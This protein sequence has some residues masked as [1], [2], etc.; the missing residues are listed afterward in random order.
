[1]KNDGNARNEIEND[2]DGNVR[3]EIED[4]NDQDGNVRNENDQTCKNGDNLVICGRT[5]I[6]EVR[7]LVKKRP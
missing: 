2:Q 6:M 3:N 5:R 7:I 1:L 4:E